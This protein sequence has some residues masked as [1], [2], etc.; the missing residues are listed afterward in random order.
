MR[1]PKVDDGVFGAARIERALQLLGVA[2]TA[3]GDLDRT[4]RCRSWPAPAFQ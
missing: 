1:L 3:H 2:S 4:I